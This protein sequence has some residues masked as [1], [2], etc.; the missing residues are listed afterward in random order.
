MVAWKLVPREEAFRSVIAQQPFLG[1][2]SK[3]HGVFRNTDLLST[4][5]IHLKIS[6][7][8]TL[9]WGNLS[10]QE[11]EIITENHKQ[12]KSRSM[13][14]NPPDSSASHLHTQ[15][16]GNIA[17]RFQEPE[18]QGVCCET[19]FPSNDRRYS[20]KSLQGNY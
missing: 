9:H 2:V 1:S 15:V 4:S 13:E 7:A 17:E 14:P 3:V 16:S 18:N 20:I 6:V 11:T 10:L 8:F 12:S 5:G 19:M